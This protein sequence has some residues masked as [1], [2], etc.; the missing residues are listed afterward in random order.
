MPQRVELSH[1]G[2]P[3]LPPNTVM[4]S[5][6]SSWGNPFALGELVWFA[7]APMSSMTIDRALATALYR[8]FIELDPQ[9]AG[10]ARRQLAGKNLACWCPLDEPCHA[11]VLLEVA[12]ATR[13]AGRVVV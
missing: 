3:F 4:V 8:R 13:R 10:S 2:K 1:H 11:D 9:L 5:P 6:P 12:N 7:G